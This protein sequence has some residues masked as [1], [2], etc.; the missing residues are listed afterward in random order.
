MSFWE[1]LFYLMFAGLAIVGVGWLIRG[2]GRLESV[3]TYTN[4]LLWVEVV[5]KEYSPSKT[6]ATHGS[7]LE[8]SPM[9]MPI[10]IRVEAKYL[11]KVIAQNG[12]HGTIDDERLHGWVKVGDRFAVTMSVGRSEDGAP[13]D[14]EVIEYPL[15]SSCREVD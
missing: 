13:R 15:E 7:V 1:V 5:D 10:V 11:V 2:M 14:W 8:L 3:Y 6:Y 4:E 9:M 12:L